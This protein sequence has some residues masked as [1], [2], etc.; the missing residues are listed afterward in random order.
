MTSTYPIAVREATAQDAA[1]IAALSRKVFTDTFVDEFGIDYRPEDLEPFLANS[2][3]Q[4]RIE[5]WIADPD[6][7]L[8]VAEQEGR[9]VGYAAAGPAAVPHPDAGAA[10]RELH[11]LYVDRAQHGA[12]AG[13][14]LMRSAMAWMEARARGAIWLGV[15]S[16][17]LR[18]QRFYARYGFE[19]AGEYDY[20]VG[21]TIDREFIMRR[22]I[23]A[24]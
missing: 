14:A 20:P 3:G 7:G 11:R 18:A 8:W 13:D 9:F 16:A 10:D 24:N 17:N 23:G 21:R 2:H 12:G 19:K 5:A 4:A 6:F 1:A 22:T 15:W